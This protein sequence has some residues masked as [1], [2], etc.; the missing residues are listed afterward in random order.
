LKAGQLQPIVV[1]TDGKDSVGMENL[2]PE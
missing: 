2:D 1:V